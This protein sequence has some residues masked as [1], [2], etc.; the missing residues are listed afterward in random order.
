MSAYHFHH[1]F[2]SLVLSFYYYFCLIFNE[3][4]VDFIKIDLRSQVIFFN[5]HFS[6][7]STILFLKGQ[8]VIFST[9]NIVHMTLS[10]YSLPHNNWVALLRKTQFSNSSV[11][12]KLKFSH[13]HVSTV[14]F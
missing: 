4:H 11:F 13:S 14:R 2:H 5:L 10:H 3:I 9:V 6:I 12:S 8:R 7:I 1:P